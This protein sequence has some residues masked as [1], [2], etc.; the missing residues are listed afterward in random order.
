MGDFEVGDT[1]LG[2]QRTEWLHPFFWED[3]TL[4]ITKRHSAQKSILLL[5]QY[6]ISNRKRK[7]LSAP[8]SLKLKDNKEWIHSSC[9]Y[10]P[11]RTQKYQGHGIGWHTWT[12]LRLAAFLLFMYSTYD[13]TERKRLIAMDYF[14]CVSFSRIILFCCIVPWAF[15][16]P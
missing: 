1:T 10:P 11:N 9:F 14:R 12:G 2:K 5:F 6:E 7:L 15:S 13:H 16:P 8:F 3:W 4:Q